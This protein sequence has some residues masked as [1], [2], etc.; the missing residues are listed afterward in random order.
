MGKKKYTEGQRT[1]DMWPRSVNVQTI[2]TEHFNYE[3]TVFN[4]RT[5]FK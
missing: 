1:T 3:E 5:T 2:T 4:E